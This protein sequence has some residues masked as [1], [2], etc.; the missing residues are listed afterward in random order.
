MAIYHPVLETLRI[1]ADTVGDVANQNLY[2]EINLFVVHL[3][4]Y[5]PEYEEYCFNVHEQLFFMRFQT[6]DQQ[7]TS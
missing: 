3:A 5:V 4:E 6:L 7:Q 2:K 1:E